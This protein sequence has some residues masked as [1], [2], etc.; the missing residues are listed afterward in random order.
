MARPGVRLPTVTLYADR[1]EIQTAY[2]KAHRPWICLTCG[3][4]F[5]LMDNMG[6][7]GCRQHPG[8]IQQD[9]RWSC[10]GQKICRV[11]W[12]ENHVHQRFFSSS[13][14]KPPYSIPPKVRGCQPCDHN[15]SQR[16]YTHKDAQPIADLSALL[17]FMN[18]TF[19][20]E[21]RTGFDKG[22]LRRCAKRPVHFPPKPPSTAQ[23]RPYLKTTLTYI[24]NDG[25]VEDGEYDALTSPP[26]LDGME[27][28]AVHVYGTEDDAIEI[29]VTH[30]WPKLV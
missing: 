29:P 8:Y 22:V 16:P 15:T 28:R 19:P 5:N 3:E 11:Q 6:G 25:H 23:G 21:L 7:L 1:H 2:D 20:F 17:P 4:Q 12:A 24:D 18:K 26:R 14:G 13:V 9:E 27:L 30:W 10:C